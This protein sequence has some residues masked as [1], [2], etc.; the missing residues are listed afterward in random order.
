MDFTKQRFLAACHLTLYK[1]G[2]IGD[3]PSQLVG[4]VSLTEGNRLLPIKTLLGAGFQFLGSVVSSIGDQPE[5]ILLFHVGC[6][7]LDF[8]RRTSPSVSSRG[9]TME[10]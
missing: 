10:P 6:M 7:V 2:G 5:R 1:S 4:R 9:M 8:I 3:F